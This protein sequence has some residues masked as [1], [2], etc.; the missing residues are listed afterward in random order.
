ME[1]SIWLKWATISYMH[2]KQVHCNNVTRAE[3]THVIMFATI[4]S[5]AYHINNDLRWVFPQSHTNLVCFFFIQVP[6][7]ILE[8]QL[9]THSTLVQTSLSMKK[10][11]WL[12]FIL[13]LSSQI[14]QYV[15]FTA[16]ISAENRRRFVHLPARGRWKL[17]Q[18]NDY[19]K[20]LYINWESSTL[21]RNLSMKCR[22][23]AFN[24]QGSTVTIIVVVWSSGSRVADMLVACSLMAVLKT[25]LSSGDSMLSEQRR[26]ELCSVKTWKN[27][28]I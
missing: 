18:R 22:D 16:L 21:A 17:T 3:L 6:V 5:S 13:H 20:D 1:C 9:D 8:F 14:L 7:Y 27:L 26:L 10:I 4:T 2:P 15:S 11:L 28:S 23:S 12:F 24:A 25:G 19:N